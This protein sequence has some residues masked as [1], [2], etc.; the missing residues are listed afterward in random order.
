M[1]DKIR[2][3]NELEQIV[4]CQTQEI[5]LMDRT[6]FNKTAVYLSRAIGLMI[7]VYDD[8]KKKYPN[9]PIIKLIREHYEDSW[10]V[11]TP[12]TYEEKFYFTL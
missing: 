6:S 4:S 11:L 2:L 8:I 5:C 7:R 9:E 12:S 1:V 10:D 3:L